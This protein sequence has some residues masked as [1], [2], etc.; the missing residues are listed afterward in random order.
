MALIFKILNRVNN[1]ISIN[2]FSLGSFFIFI[3][4]T[5]RYYGFSNT[6]VEF[7]DNLDGA[8]VYWSLLYNHDFSYFNPLSK[9]ENIA[10]G[11]EVGNVFPSIIIGELFY[12]VM[13]PINAYALNEL[14]T[15]LVAFIGMNLLLCKYFTKNTE[16]SKI[17]FWVSLCFSFLP[18]N[19]TPFLTISGQP[20]L[21]FSFLNILRGEKNYYNYIII[22]IFPFYSSLVLAGF[23][24]CFSMTLIW[25]YFSCHKRKLNLVGF[26]SIVLI[27]LLYI[28]S[29][30]KLIYIHFIDTDFISIRSLWA[31]YQNLPLTNSIEIFKSKFIENIYKSFSIFI[32]G[33]EHAPS[34][35]TYFIFSPILITICLSLSK[36]DKQNIS[37]IFYVLLLVC[38]LIS[39][40]YGYWNDFIRVLSVDNYLLT[41]FKWTRFHWLQPIIWYILFY[42]SLV[43]IFISN[44]FLPKTKVSLETYKF[45]FLILA[46]LCAILY[47]YYIDIV[48]DKYGR[49]YPHIVSMLKILP[50]I[51]S[52][53][54]LLTFF[55]I[56]LFKEK[57]YK[58]LQKFPSINSLI[59][60]P[61]L[62]IITLLISG[63][64][65]YNL[66]PLKI[67][68]I[69][70][71]NNIKASQ[72]HGGLKNTTFDDYFLVETF[73]KIN[74]YIDQE[75]I[76]YRVISI[77]FSPSIPLFNGF[78]TL[79]MYLPSYSASYK[80]DFR[81][82]IERELIQNRKIKEYFDQSGKRCYVF[83][84]DLGKKWNFKK[85]ELP[86]S[87]TI[88][89]NI[90]KFKIMGGKFIF[91]A[92]K[93]DNPQD[94]SLK[95]HK[96]FKNN[97][98]KKLD[99][100]LYEAI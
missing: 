90:K 43:N 79:D 32:F 16:T 21:L 56:L 70:V 80:N 71:V 13:H 94:N 84:S 46:I 27:S 64:I 99:I 12:M 83:I 67:G 85:H 50:L 88:N 40:F 59:S 37:Y 96:L 73:K 87:V 51:I 55:Y 19:P 25:L 30:Y 4:L 10:N 82:I 100:Y 69:F 1:T 23:A 45:L 47:F 72:H 53:S 2:P 57:I 92:V 78:F 38:F 44:T 86:S 54:L 28:I 26:W 8:F 5:I 29:N 63:Q 35:H 42:I 7:H 89:L 24:I 34:L 77:G 41:S 95:F 97:D 76:N 52:T 33:Q 66:N 61:K 65:I 11:I 49:A 36:K 22:I 58:Y 20:L 62:L 68:K 14:I 9:I 75:Q 15:R 48:V 39:L 17:S 91:S 31:N 98:T 60:S 6:Y 93:I 74:N 81:K 18:F 3:Y